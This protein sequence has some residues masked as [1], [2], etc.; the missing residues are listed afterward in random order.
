MSSEGLVVLN[1]EI[2]EFTM[3]GFGQFRPNLEVLH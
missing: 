3:S 1:Y 2:L